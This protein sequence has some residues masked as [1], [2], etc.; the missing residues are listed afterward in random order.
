[1]EALFEGD[2]RLFGLLDSQGSVILPPIFSDL[3]FFD[4]KSGLARATYNDGKK[5]LKGYVNKEGMFMIMVG[6]TESE[7]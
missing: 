6:K 1:M 5:L 3:T 7:W 2:V 4:S